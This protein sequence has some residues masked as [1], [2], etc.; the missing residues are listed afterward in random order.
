M[1][2][3]E[4][5]A[6][7]AESTVCL[8][9]CAASDAIELV[10]IEHLNGPSNIVS[11]KLWGWVV[12]DLG[13]QCSYLTVMM[14]DFCAMCFYCCLCGT[15]CCH[16]AVIFI[17]SAWQTTVCLNVILLI[18]DTNAQKHCYYCVKMQI[19]C[20]DNLC[21]VQFTNTKLEMRVQLKEYYRGETFWR[22]C[23]FNSAITSSFPGG[24][25]FK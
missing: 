22:S 11:Q 1:T 20:Q 15:L 25:N 17:T 7:P 2:P 9:D 14:E 24:I 16:S 10:L 6:L 23:C 3:W 8:I 18:P 19:W 4:M 13:T 21:K 12:S 5:A